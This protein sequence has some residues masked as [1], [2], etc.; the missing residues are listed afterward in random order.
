MLTRPSS[1]TEFD[2]VKTSVRRQAVHSLLAELL[3]PSHRPASFILRLVSESTLALYR[4][5]CPT[6]SV[7]PPL[8]LNLMLSGTPSLSVPV[9]SPLARTGSKISPSCPIDINAASATILGAFD[10][11]CELQI[12]RA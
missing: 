8:R 9:A 3:S 4:S 12:G 5:G 10:A 2:V 7:R 11:D 6:L 1:C